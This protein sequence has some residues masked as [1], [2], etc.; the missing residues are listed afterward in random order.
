MIQDGTTAVMWAS[1]SG[2]FTIVE[3]LVQQGADINTQNEV[4]NI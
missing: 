4:R 1:I 3:Y 2:H